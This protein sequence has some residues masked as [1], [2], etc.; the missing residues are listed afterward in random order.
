MDYPKHKKENKMATINYAM[1]D[2]S[3]PDA[4]GVDKFK[5]T[6]TTESIYSVSGKQ[7]ALFTTELIKS[8]LKTSNITITDA[9]SNVGSDAIMF[10]L[11]FDKVNSIELDPINFSALQNNVRVYG[12][13]NINLIMG[14]SLNYLDKLHQDV[15]YIDAPWGGVDYKKHKN[16]RLYLGTME[17]SD[18]YLKYKQNARLFVFKVPVNYDMN[19]FIYR[20]RVEKFNVHG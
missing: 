19:Y 10:A 6:M 9:T 4:S 20:T 7:G 3:F 14:D 16:L 2:K 11:H 12:L 1:A 18:I 15:I 8:Y 17:L 5:L 13:K